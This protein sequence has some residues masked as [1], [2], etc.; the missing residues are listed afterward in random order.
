LFSQ[1]ES[2]SPVYKEKYRFN[3]VPYIL[4]SAFDA[5]VVQ[6]FQLMRDA[7]AGKAAAQ[8]ELALRYLLGRGLP[9]DT[10]KAVYWMMKA[11]QQDLPF[12]HYNLGIMHVQGIGVP[13][14]PF[15]AYK[16]FRSA[17]D[18]EIPEALFMMGV[19]YSENFV[20]PRSWPKTFDYIK[21]SAAYGMSD[22]KDALKELRRRGVDSVETSIKSDTLKKKN[23]NNGS[24]QTAR[25][26]T[27]MQLIFVDFHTDTTSVTDDTT[28]VHEAYQELNVSGKESEPKEREKVEVDST[29]RS[30][31]LTAAEIG[32]P[33]ALCV[34]GRCYEKGWSV[35]KDQILAAEYYFRAVRAESFR[36][37]ALLWR[38]IN[39]EHF[40][41]ELEIR[42]AKND[43]DALFVWAGLTAIDFAKLLSG[44][45]ALKIL[46]RAAEDGHVLSM[47]ELGQCYF[48]GRWTAQDKMEAARWWMQA[49]KEGSTDAKFRIAMLNV[50]GEVHSDPPD[51]T[52]T[53]LQ[54][55][56]RQG[57]L[58]ASAGIG[59]CYEVGYGVLQNKGEAYR[60][61]HAALHRGS[62]TSYLALQR[63][64]DEIRPGE[65]EFHVGN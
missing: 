2:K 64:H 27:T 62:E 6:V 11:A 60:I 24:A 5:Q 48:T 65:P 9:F 56:S 19:M 57:S 7:N 55:L 44:E 26:D 61:Y 20:V 37:P 35:K 21:R 25:N 39:T 14:N 22:A 3:G 50:A 58:L 49:A 8:H 18:E 13:W 4:Y 31:L 33:E 23:P 43:R 42:T 40:S 30:L 28:L 16:H 46:K 59:L 1:D 12:A 54:N 34:L 47:V 52:F 36:A 38:L 15:E 51:T 45:Q 29:R 63:M 32:N 10:S 41:H 17:A 53:F